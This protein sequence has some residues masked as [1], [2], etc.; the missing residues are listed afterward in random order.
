MEKMKPRLPG[1]RVFSWE[2]GGDWSPVPG[3]QIFSGGN[4]IIKLAASQHDYIIITLKVHEMA[5]VV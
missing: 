4:I 3:G 5:K 1:S 2:N